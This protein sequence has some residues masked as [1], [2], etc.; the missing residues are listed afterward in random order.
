MNEM[1]V[2][3]KSQW[4]SESLPGIGTWGDR[5]EWKA[6]IAPIGSIC[7]CSGRSSLWEYQSVILRKVATMFGP[8]IAK[9][10]VELDQTVFSPA[11]LSGARGVFVPKN[12]ASG[13]SSHTKGPE[14]VMNNPWK[15]QANF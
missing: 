2:K 15:P 3:L 1:G 11:F 13:V 7:K 12:D 5:A 8:H 4:P 9:G 14:H 10:L 6:G